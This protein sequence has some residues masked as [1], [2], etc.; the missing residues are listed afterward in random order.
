MKRS[1]RVA[2]AIGAA[3]AGLSAW[4]PGA[5]AST[6]PIGTL[7]QSV[8]ADNGSAQGINGYQ[9][10]AQTFEAGLSGSLTSISVPLNG[11]DSGNTDL[12]VQLTAVDGTG[13]PSTLLATTTIPA[14]T[15]GNGA[16][17]W[18]SEC[19]AVA[20]FGSPTTVTAGQTYAIVLSTTGATYGWH[21]SNALTSPQNWVA[22]GG[23]PWTAGWTTDFST[24]VLPVGY[25]FSGFLAPLNNAPTVNTGK[26]GRTYPVKFQLQDAN[27]NYISA[28]SAVKSVTYK[29]TSC[30]AFSG[31]PTDA[32]ETTTTGGT[33]LTYDSIANQYVYNWATPS[34]GCYTLFLTLDSGQV[35]PAYFNLS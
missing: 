11:S 18:P 8:T 32:L 24:Y 9:T 14:A 22:D 29:S 19:T 20:N 34:T 6:A 21:G 1:L 26:S 7:D 35:Y 17:P 28:L 13:M 27:G 31:D 4:A 33:S 23:G 12:T 2:I 30:S 10:V 3:L 16:C 25:Q 5:L 15:V